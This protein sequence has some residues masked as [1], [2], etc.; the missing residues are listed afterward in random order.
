MITK[1]RNVFLC[2]ICV[3]M[4]VRM[5]PAYFFFPSALRIGS[6]EV[7]KMGS[8]SGGFSLFGRYFFPPLVVLI[9]S[10]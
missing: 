6:Y 5:R 4:R 7:K 3:R 8:K 2:T 9:H 10:T 1:K